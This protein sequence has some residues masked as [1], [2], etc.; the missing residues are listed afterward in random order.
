MAGKCPECSEHTLDCKCTDF[1]KERSKLF[2]TLRDAIPEDV[3]HIVLVDVLLWFVFQTSYPLNS[4]ENLKN[5]CNENFTLYEKSIK[6]N[7]D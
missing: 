4:L 7:N 2:L 5:Y 1:E 3:N 6:E